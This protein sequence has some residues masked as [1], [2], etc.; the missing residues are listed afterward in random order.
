MRYRAETYNQALGSTGAQQLIVFLLVALI[1]DGG[2]FLE[3]CAVAAFAFWIGVGFIW[4]R[5]RSKPTTADL[6]VIEAGFIPV[7]AISF[8]F[9]YWI[10]RWRGVL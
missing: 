1:L 3:V 6:L 10:W 8:L 5:R 9:S 2:V 7:C 4:F